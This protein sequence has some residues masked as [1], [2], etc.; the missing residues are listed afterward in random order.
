MLFSSVGRG[1]V[2]AA[3]DPGLTPGLGPFAACHAHSV[4]SSSDLSTKA[5]T[6]Q[7]EQ[8]ISDDNLSRIISTSDPLSLGRIFIC[9]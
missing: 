6:N 5:K 1:L 4:K 2:L 3:A 8:Q 7:T 9:V